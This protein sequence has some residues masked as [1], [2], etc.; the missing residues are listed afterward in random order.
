MHLP[1]T[2]AIDR[3]HGNDAN[4]QGQ[5][6]NKVNASFWESALK[7][8]FKSVVF[9]WAIPEKKTKRR[10]EDTFLKKTPGISFVFLCTPGNSRQNKAPLLEIW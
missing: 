1:K 9:E 4:V 5:I 6:A 7:D 10:F 2:D 8:Q 3:A